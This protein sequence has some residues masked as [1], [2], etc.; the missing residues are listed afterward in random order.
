[1]LGTMLA[2]LMWIGLYPQPLLRTFRPV[3]DAMQAAAPLSLS[4]RR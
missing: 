1:M 3:I 2:C 4:A